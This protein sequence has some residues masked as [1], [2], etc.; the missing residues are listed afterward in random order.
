MYSRD[1]NCFT[2]LNFE[3]ITINIPFCPGYVFSFSM[4]FIRAFFSY[5]L[6]GYNSTGA[7]IGSFPVTTSHY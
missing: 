6:Y 4:V 5:L 3:Y 2:N 1:A 7:L